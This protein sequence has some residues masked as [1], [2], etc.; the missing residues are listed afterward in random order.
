MID[1]FDFM[2]SR[3]YVISEKQYEDSIKRHREKE[4]E[5]L[6]ERKRYHLDAVKKLD[7]ALASLQD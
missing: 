2:P 5:R 1:L 7:A 6:E 3:V 4:R